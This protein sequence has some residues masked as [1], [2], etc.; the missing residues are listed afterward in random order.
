MGMSEDSAIPVRI[1]LV[2][3]VLA[4]FAGA[5]GGIA[6]VRLLGPPD[7]LPVT[8]SPG[9]PGVPGDP[10]AEGECGPVGAPGESGPP[11]PQGLPGSEG[12]P[13]PAGPSGPAGP[14]GPP[15]AAG[16]A[17]PQGEQGEQGPQGV[18][19]PQG[20]CPPERDYGLF[21]DDSGDGQRGTA[22]QSQ[23]VLLRSTVDARGIRVEDGSRLILPTPGTYE[24]LFSA[25][26][27]KPSVQQASSVEIWFQR[28]LPGG[29][30][31]PIAS[32]NTRVFLPKDRDSYEVMTVS[33]LV[34]TT[35]ADEFLELYWHTT[36]SE[37]ILATVAASD[38]RPAIPS[39]IVTVLPVG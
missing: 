2:G 23:P 29:S 33:L 4:V 19:G 37:A 34:T 24:V 11:G 6:G 22:G 9:P 36:A 20:E 5:A 28:G 10:G 32:S 18:Q 15:G 17:G 35:T 14:E 39:V 31:S 8:G 16:P 26:I 1:V 7:A 13:G 25:Q 21:I 12:Q 38:G 27:H 3:L 30:S